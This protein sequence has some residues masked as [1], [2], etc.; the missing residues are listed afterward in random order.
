M[1]HVIICRE[2]PPAPSG[3]IG[4]YVQNI[5]QLLAE[6]GETVHVIG[7]LW[8]D[9]NSVTEELYNGKL[10][11][12][13][14][15]FEEPAAFFGTRMSSAIQSELEKSL[16]ASD[17]PAQCF[18]WQAG[19]LAERLVD[20]E[21][22]DIIEAQDYEAPLYYFQ[23]RRALGLGSKRRPPCIVH[24]HSPTEFIGRYNDWNMALPRW[25][26][27][28][29]LED[30][31]IAS[32]DHWL[33]PSSYFA[34]QAQTQYGLPKDLIEIIPYPLGDFLPVQRN[35]ETWST[36]SVIYV[37]RLER[38][39]GLLEWIE[40]AVDIARENP[41]ARFEFVGANVLGA[42]R[43]LSEAVLDRLIP[44]GLRERF[45]FHG[46]VD[47]SAIR[48]LLARARVGVVPSRW[49]N[50]PNA[51]MEAMSSGLP[52]IASPEGGMVE[53]I[54]DGRNGWLAETA[55]KKG[56]QEVLK[57]A[58]GTPPARIAEMGEAAAK[59]VGEI[60]HPLQIVDRHL[61]F[62]RRVVDRGAN[63]S[64]SPS[65]KPLKGVADAIRNAP[66]IIYEE[67]VGRRPELFAQDAEHSAVTT[68]TSANASDSG[69]YSKFDEPL[70]T[71]R[72]LLGNPGITFRIFQQA[73]SELTR[74]SKKAGANGL[75]KNS[76][77]T[78]RQAQGERRKT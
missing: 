2:Y 5:S 22:I 25:V 37:G 63:G 71:I 52:V 15:P 13:R 34:R 27:A 51:C 66:K 59:S 7:Q 68:T 19:A 40:A 56:L 75:L 46:K 38:R 74:R 10:I 50:F 29:R 20:N 54:T 57:R 78:F 32:A 64:L 18:S 65:W 6:N 41:T 9:A 33:C 73:T 24:L 17:F 42:N 3:G 60:C 62:R 44:R 43:I 16:Y 53:M 55:D 76:P 1:K 12:H 30:Y 72:C 49:D 67:F 77:F 48:Q 70:A 58:L 36:G 23:L 39:K 61:S 69:W 21:G 47:R 8:E 26:T 45:A 11:L 4:T 35:H 31:S 14:L 28:K